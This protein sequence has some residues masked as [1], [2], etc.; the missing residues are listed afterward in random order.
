MYIETDNQVE[1][2]D[3][4]RTGGETVEQ[5]DKW[6]TDNQMDKQTDNGP[7]RQP[8]NLMNKHADNQADKQEDNLHVVVREPYNQTDRETWIKHTY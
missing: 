3:K 4:Q 8:Y 2:T 6:R 1:P 5:L 7:Q